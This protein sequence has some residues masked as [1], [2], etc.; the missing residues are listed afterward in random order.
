MS[1]DEHQSPTGQYNFT[2][3][4]EKMPKLIFRYDKD[5]YPND[6]DLPDPQVS[7]IIPGKRVPLD[8][9]GIAPVDLPIKVYRRDSGDQELQAQASLYS[10]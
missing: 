6:D 9:V 4:A 10:R 5:F 7:P 3:Y 8:K 2:D 1:N